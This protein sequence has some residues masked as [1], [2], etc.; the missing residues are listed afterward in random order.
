MAGGGGDRR[1][2]RTD[3]RLTVAGTARGPLRILPC[4]STFSPGGKETRAVRL[5]NA[6]GN[7][8]H[9]TI[10]SAVPDALGARAL[11]APGI[12]ADFPGDARAPALHGRPGITRYAALTRYMQGFDLV[13]S[14]NWGAMDAVMAHRLFAPIRRLPPLIHHEDG[15]NADESARL[16]WRRN[17]FR[18]AALPTARAVV[19]PSHVLEDIARRHWGRR[20][21]VTRIS[22]G[23]PVAAYAAPQQPGAI[24]GFARREGE[25]VV[26]TIAGLRPVKDLPLLVEALALTPPNVRLV[27]VGEGPERD[28]IAATAA[29]LGVADRLLMPGFLADPARYVG[30]FD[31]MALSSLSEQQPIAVMEGMAA[32]LPIVAPSVG[33][34][35][36]MV[37]PANRPFIPPRSAAA[38]AE[39]IT[40]LARNPTLRAQIG[41][42]NRSVAAAEFDEAVMIARYAALYGVG[43]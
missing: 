22:N 33:D 38:L 18:R 39:S 27:I 32:G 25:V 15:F 35:A 42:A 41:A 12:V 6:F 10:L 16:D 21:P 11:I 34:V 4:H 19:V 31:I 8:V 28:G 1:A 3:Q 2:A 5:M 43:G 13:L 7:R 29:R 14:Y 17:A 20:L 9:H 26:G 36:A 24:P 30:H 37:A 23:I 40:L